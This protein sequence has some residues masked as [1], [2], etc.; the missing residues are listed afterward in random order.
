MEL[1]CLL[2]YLISMFSS[3]L[4]WNALVI[5]FSL[6]TECWEFLK[7]MFLQYG[8]LFLHFGLAKNHCS[9]KKPLTHHQSEPTGRW[10]DGDVRGH[11]DL[12]EGV[13]VVQTPP[14][15]WG[16]LGA[17]CEAVPRPPGPGC[18]PGLLIPPQM[19]WLTNWWGLQ[20]RTQRSH[21]WTLQQVYS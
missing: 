15:G 5:S 21:H 11:D 8:I 4:C 3:S 16:C 9:S 18:P 2:L 19:D 1:Q 6:F 13:C 14:A 20:W 17:A 10:K 7:L 12:C